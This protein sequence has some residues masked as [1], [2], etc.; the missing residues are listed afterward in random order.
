MARSSR[1]LSRTSRHLGR[2]STEQS[3]CCLPLRSLAFH[4]NAAI[5]AAPLAGIRLAGSTAHE[6]TD[7]LLT[8]LVALDLV[9]IFTRAGS[10]HWHANPL[11]ILPLTAAR[12]GKRGHQNASD[13]Q[14]DSAHIFLSF[15]WAAPHL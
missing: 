5:F 8:I 2:S 11:D 4:L 14:H 7:F 3:S 12:H 1:M 9:P 6:R 13:R 10:P 15:W